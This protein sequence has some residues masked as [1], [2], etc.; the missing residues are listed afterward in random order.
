MIIAGFMMNIG[1]EIWTLLS[2]SGGR[3]GDQKKLVILRMLQMLILDQMNKISFLYVVLRNISGR[4]WGIL[5]HTSDKTY[6]QK[7]SMLLLRNG[8]QP[9]GWVFWVLMSSIIPRERGEIMIFQ[10]ILFVAWIWNYSTG[11]KPGERVD[12]AHLAAHRYSVRFY[13]KFCLAVCFLHQILVCTS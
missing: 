1:D 13:S 12:M 9:F 7:L 2:I 3:S 8:F 5:A 4:T 10:C 11:L 6:W